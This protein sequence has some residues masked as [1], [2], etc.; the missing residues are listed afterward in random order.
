MVGRDMNSGLA[1]ATPRV[2]D[3]S[4]AREHRSTA[5]VLPLAA[6]NLSLAGLTARIR[7]C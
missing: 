3:L 2:R 6:K 7:A 1:D 4:V 5:P